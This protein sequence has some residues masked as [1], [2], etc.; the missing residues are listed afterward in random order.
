MRIEAFPYQTVWATIDD[1]INPDYLFLLGDQIYMDFGT[2]LFGREPIR[3]PKDLS[4]KKFVAGMDKKYSEQ[5]SEPNFRKLFRRLKRKDR[6]FGVW[7]D[8][9]FAWDNAQ[10]EGPGAVKESYKQASRRLFNKW[11]YGEESDQEVYRY[12][13][14]PHARVIFLDCR[15][16]SE[17]S[18][19]ESTLL[20]EEQFNFLEASLKHDKLFTVIA[21]GITLTQTPDVFSMSNKYFVKNKERWSLYIKEFERLKSLLAEHQRVLYIAGDIHRNSFKEHSWNGKNVFEVVSSGAAIDHVGLRSIDARR[22]FGVLDFDQEKI[23]VQ[24]W[25]KDV[26]QVWV[27]DIACWAVER[28]PNVN[29]SIL[30]RMNGAARVKRISCKFED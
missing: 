12:I 22:N 23:R 21:N 11:V 1:I 2:R 5:W 7:D 19:E 17:G 4:L 28:Y 15:Y 29:P 13:D 14:L 3:S 18:G 26:P 27:I 30:G 6:V 24:L 8:H 16:Y 9:D 25:T 10:G 20:G